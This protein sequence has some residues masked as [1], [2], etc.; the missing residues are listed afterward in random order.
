M[1]KQVIR[2]VAKD[3]ADIV[4]TSQVVGNPFGLVLEEL[5][6]GKKECDTHDPERREEG[7]GGAFRGFV[8]DRVSADRNNDGTRTTKDKINML[9]LYPSFYVT[10]LYFTLDTACKIVSY[11]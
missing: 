6:R 10:L 4:S 1:T 7:G 11:Q 2:G 8:T 3:I 5:I 9:S